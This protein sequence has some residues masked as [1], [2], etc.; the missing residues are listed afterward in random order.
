MVKAKIWMAEACRLRK[1]AEILLKNAQELEAK[2]EQHA[3]EDSNIL[4]YRAFSAARHEKEFSAD[5]LNFAESCPD[6][7][8][9]QEF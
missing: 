6:A 2:A 1:A 7:D 3:R 4:S 8:R 5:P 9:Q